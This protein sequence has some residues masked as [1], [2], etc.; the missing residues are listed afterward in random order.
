MGGFLHY[1]LVRSDYLV[2]QGTL[3]PC[4]RMLRLRFP[5]RARKP[6]IEAPK[7]LTISLASKQGV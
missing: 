5:V 7:V 2:L 6:K 1:G 4:K 3:G